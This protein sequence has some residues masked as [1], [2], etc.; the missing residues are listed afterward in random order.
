MSRSDRKIARR[1]SGFGDRT[2]DTLP[3]SDDHQCSII[4]S[5]H[6]GATELGNRNPKAH[7]G[8]QI[9]SA[10]RSTTL[11]AFLPIALFAALVTAIAFLG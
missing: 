6:L 3:C 10:S 2:Y 8:T 1:S 7:I 4:N 9:R 11:A 5:D